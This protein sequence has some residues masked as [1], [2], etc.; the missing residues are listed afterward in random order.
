M[1]KEKK[2]FWRKKKIFITGHTGFK[3]SWL[4]LILLQFGAEVCGYSLKPKKKSIFNFAKLKNKINKNI[5]SNIKNYKNLKKSITNFKPDIIFH[6]AAQPLVIPSYLNPV[7]TFKV[8][9]IGTLN[10]LDIIKDISYKGSAIIVTTDKVYNVTNKNYF[11][12]NDYMDVT[13][14]YGTSKVC[15]EL[16]SKSYDIS[17]LKKKY[18]SIGTARAGNVLGG[19][20]FSKYRIVPDYLKA[21]KLKKDLKLRNPNYIRPW[22]Y[23]LEPLDG[24]LNLAE[25]LYKKKIYNENIGWN[26]APKRSNC[27]KVIDLIKQLNKKSRNKIKILKNNVKQ[28]KF[29][30]TKTLMLNS[31]KAKKLL[32]WKSCYGI[33]EIVN[34]ILYWYENFDEN[35]DNYNLCINQIKRFYRN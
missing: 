11:K 10:I 28:N 6:L 3:G 29:K 21:S 18:F 9:T 8:N 35:K 31:N 13:D 20:D 33:N 7:D 5:Y 2:N 32:G 14:P 25:K 12:E 26:F 17:F 27:V 23:V 34:E 30:E 4:S 15:A 16:I 1:I 24:Y 19:G 22:Q